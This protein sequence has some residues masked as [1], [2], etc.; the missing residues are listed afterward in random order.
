[1][2]RAVLDRFTVEIE[3]DAPSGDVPAL[4]ETITV[5]SDIVPSYHFGEVSDAAAYGHR[6][7]SAY[8]D[9]SDDNR[10]LDSRGT[11]ITAWTSGSRPQEP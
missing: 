10:S 4:I 5:L 3:A 2:R 11:A 7:P 6:V 1:M 8:A 9:V